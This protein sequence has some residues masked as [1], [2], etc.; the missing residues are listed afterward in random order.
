[1]V[2]TLDALLKSYSPGEI[3]QGY[4]IVSVELKGIE[5]PT[6]QVVTLDALPLS[7]SPT[8]NTIA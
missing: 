5:P 6:F 7:Y 3:L 4:F 1:M 8:S 2:V